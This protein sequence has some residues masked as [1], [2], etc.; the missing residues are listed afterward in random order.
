MVCIY[1]GA[2]THVINSRSQRRA[3]QVWRRRECFDCRAVFTTEE[4]AQYHSA[5]SVKN[6]D[7]QLQPFSRDKL[8]LSLHKVCAHRPTATADAGSL[9]DTVIKKLAPHASDGVIN[10]LAVIQAVQVAL[11]RFDHVASVQY[12]ALHKV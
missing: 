10:R 2:K 4:V 6:T 5:W 3:N 8:M 1:C 9:T 7:N 11:N 12:Q